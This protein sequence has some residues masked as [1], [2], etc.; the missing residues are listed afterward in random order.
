MV[1]NLEFT[2]S[3]EVCFAE[4][5][6]FH[7]KL[8]IWKI[9]PDALIPKDAVPC[10]GRFT[11]VLNQEVVHGFICRN[12]VTMFFFRPLIKIDR[13]ADTE[14]NAAQGA[15][16]LKFLFH[17]IVKIIGDTA[18]GAVIIQRDLIKS[19]DH[20]TVIA[21]IPPHGVKFFFVVGDRAVENFFHFDGRHPKRQRGRENFRNMLDELDRYP[22]LDTTEALVRIASQNLMT[23]LTSK[24]EEDWSKIGVDKLMNQISGLTRAVAYKRRVELQNK[25]DLEAGADDVKAM[26]WNAMAKERP[27]L[28]KQVSAYLDRK[29]REGGA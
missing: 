17:R 13:I 14:R 19:T 6:Q 26:L 22:D 23:A 28:Y 9:P 7:S 18:D 11:V 1:H 27:D 15:F 24:K 20:I 29:T 21:R 3:T 12:D 10:M 4:K 16:V 25:T 2:L 5:V 8:L